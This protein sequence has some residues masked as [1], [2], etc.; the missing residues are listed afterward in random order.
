MTNPTYV[1]GHLG[2]DTDTVVSA[3]LAADFL[4]QRE[5]TDAYVPAVTGPLN[6]ET[7]FVLDYFNV[8]VPQLLTDAAGAD[9]FLVDHNE[10]V[11]TVAGY[12]NIVGIIDHH[13]FN[14]ISSNPIEIIC[15][16][17]GS[18]ATVLLDMYANA[19]IQV[20][21]ELRGILLCA[22]LSD[23]VIL[24]SPTTTERDITFVQMLAQDLQIDYTDL[25]MQLF[26]AKAQVASKS[27]AEIIHNDFK[28]F[29]V[30]GKNVGLGQIE[31]PSLDVLQPKL[32][33]I[34][35]ELQRMKPNY[36][37]LALML[38]DIV[39][40]GTQLIVVSDSM[41][42]LATAFNT[43][44]VEHVSNFIPGMMSRKKQVVPVITEVLG[45]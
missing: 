14:F 15:K 29:D 37:T 12:R 24:R 41:E 22:M 17:W 1:I 19:G 25:G 39:Q 38:T 26:N 42:E 44:L 9:I 43:T 5:N 6:S 11:Q 7:Q 8:A 2:P 28:N 3:I 13:T 30:A 27:A 16:P 33:E 34:I 21:A 10:A 36:H 18:T 45:A 23:T 4:N 40:E 32:P 31:V 20:P 35:A